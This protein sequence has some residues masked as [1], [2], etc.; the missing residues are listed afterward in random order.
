[1]KATQKILQECYIRSSKQNQSEGK[2]LADALSC[3]YSGNFTTGYKENYVQTV[4]KN[5]QV[6]SKIPSI[7]L[8]NKELNIAASDSS[9]GDEGSF[10]SQKETNSLISSNKVSGLIF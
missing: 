4:A 6:S 7:H 2:N 10:M 3:Y 1:M 9:S 8:V 5:A